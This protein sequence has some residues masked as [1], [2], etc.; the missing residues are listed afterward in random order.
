MTAVQL[1]CFILNHLSFHFLLEYEKKTQITPRGEEVRGGR[2]MYRAAEWER[3]TRGRRW[4]C[5][6][7]ICSTR[8]YM[9]FFFF[10]QW[11]GILSSKHREPADL[12][13]ASLSD[14]NRKYHIPRQLRYIKH[15][16]C[17]Q[18]QRF[19]LLL[20]V[21][22]WQQLGIHTCDWCAFSLNAASPESERTLNILEGVRSLKVWKILEF[23]ISYIQI[24]SR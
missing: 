18:W 16:R 24:V 19:E 2:E 11:Y 14:R 15:S 7:R 21:S 10:S 1:I 8:I 4:I 17:W 9:I 22:E 23:S 12:K 20:W 3:K 5:M 13:K 6:S